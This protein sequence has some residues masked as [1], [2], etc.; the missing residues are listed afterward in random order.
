MHFST[1][2]QKNRPLVENCKL[3]EK[4]FVCK[5]LISKK[6]ENASQALSSINEMLENIKSSLL[7]KPFQCVP[8]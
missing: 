2:Q 5:A 4:F 8:Q 3:A 7:L 1:L 6:Q